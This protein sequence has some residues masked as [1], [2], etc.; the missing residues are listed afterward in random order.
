MFVTKNGMVKKT[1]LSQY[2]AQRYSRALTALNLKGDD[3]V[4]AVHETTGD[5]HLFLNT[6]LGYGL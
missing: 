2:K 6:C 3:E 4:V 5:T 1:E